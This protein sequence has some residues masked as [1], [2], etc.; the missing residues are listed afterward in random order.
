MSQLRSNILVDSL[1]LKLSCFF[2]LNSVHIIEEF[3]LHLLFLTV[4]DEHGILQENE[5]NSDQKSM[6]LENTKYF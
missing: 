5:P 6:V 4:V 3:V 1:P 2:G